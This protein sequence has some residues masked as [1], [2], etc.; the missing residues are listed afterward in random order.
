M[1][2]VKVIWQS[3]GK[4]AEGRKVSLGFNALFSGGVTNSEYTDRNGEAHFNAENGEGQVFVDGSTKHKGY[5]SGRVVVY[6]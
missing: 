5:L 1:I 2:T 4:P 3:T 6:I